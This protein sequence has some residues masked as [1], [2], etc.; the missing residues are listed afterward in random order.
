MK[1]KYTGLADSSLFLLLKYPLLTS[2]RGKC[3]PHSSRISLCDLY[4][5]A[6]PDQRIHTNV[7]FLY[8]LLKITIS[9]KIMWVKYYYSKNIW[10]KI[11]NPAYS[12]CNL[13]P[14]TTTYSHVV[15]T[16]YYNSVSRNSFNEMSKK[17][18]RSWCHWAKL[19]VFWWKKKTKFAIRLEYATQ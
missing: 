1:P 3:L 13:G 2:C 18:H 15:I 6:S 17:Y 12:P 16:Q 4:C 8:Q 9:I 5:R 7:L 14:L 19:Q 10:F 11:T